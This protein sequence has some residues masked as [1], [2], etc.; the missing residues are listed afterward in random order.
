MSLRFGGLPDGESTLR[1]HI[2]HCYPEGRAVSRQQTAMAEVSPYRK[3]NQSENKKPSPG[4]VRERVSYQASIWWIAYRRIHPTA[5][6][7]ISPGEGWFA[8]L[9]FWRIAVANPPYGLGYLSGSAFVPLSGQP[10][11]L[12]VAKISLASSIAVLLSSISVSGSSNTAT[13]ALTIS[14]TCWVL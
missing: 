7:R 8:W 10:S 13:A 1:L 2:F 12:A 11:S 5:L 9:R 4:K 14:M 3:I 6:D